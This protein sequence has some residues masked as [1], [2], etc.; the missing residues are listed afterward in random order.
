MHQLALSAVPNW[1][2]WANMWIPVSVD[3]ICPHCGRMVNLPLTAHSHDVPRNTVS[4][5]AL[6]PACSKT[7]DFWILRPGDGRDSSKRGCEML[8]IYPRPRAIRE[9]IV[10]PDKIGNLSLSRAYQSTLAA[11]NVGLWTACAAS[12]RRTLE[13]LVFSLL[14]EESRK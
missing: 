4:A 6:C 1:A 9:P 2:N 8:S 7:S 12:C 5:T 13:G 10:S 11:Y 3:T 14:G